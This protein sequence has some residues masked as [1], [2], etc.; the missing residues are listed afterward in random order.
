M[1]RQKLII[2]PFNGNGLEALD[3]IDPALFDFVGFIDDDDKKR[4]QPHPWAVMDRSGFSRFP[5]ARV[6]AV[7]GSP[8]T[9]LE[10]GNIIG[11]L[12]V[13]ET[14]LV[15][16]IHPGA[17]IGHSVQIGTNC[18]IMAGVVLT[19]NAVIGDHVCIMPNTVIHHDSVI[20]SRTLIGCNVAVAGRTIIGPN[21]YI[22]SGANILNDL[23][24]GANALIGMGS[25]VIRDVP[26]NSRVVGNP[27]RQI[28]GGNV[29]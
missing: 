20:E 21:C 5:D 22:G 3:C 26:R 24:I 7:P 18:L 23:H 12:P 4:L 10:R 25:N 17:R 13:P 16:V 28:V 9:Y 19:S 15:S 2:F 1:T 27:A 11:A 8:Q 29:D 6:L 14:R